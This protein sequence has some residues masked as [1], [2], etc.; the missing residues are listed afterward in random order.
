[1]RNFDPNYVGDQKIVQAAIALSPVQVENVAELA[2]D[3]AAIV[4]VAEPLINNIE[5]ISVASGISLV[6]G[7]N[8]PLGEDLLKALVGV[9]D[10]VRDRFGR[11]QSE[12]VRRLLS[13]LIAKVERCGLKN[14]ASCFSYG[15]VQ[16]ATYGY[17]RRL[18]VFLWGVWEPNRP[19]LIVPSSPE[20]YRSFEFAASAAALAL[21]DALAGKAE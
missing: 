3:R 1:V 7:Y 20:G 13:A 16:T 4:N 9:S 14:C 8:N 12:A 19:Q 6:R 15:I 10:G 17:R 2:P 18:R 21:K 11:D 5:P